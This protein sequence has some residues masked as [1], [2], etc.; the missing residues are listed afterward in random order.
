M[1]FRKIIRTAVLILHFISFN[2]LYDNFYQVVNN[3]SSNFFNFY[4]FMYILTFF[5]F[6]LTF[7]KHILEE[8]LNL[9]LKSNVNNYILNKFRRS[10]E[11]MYIPILFSGY[12]CNIISN[13]FW[14]TVT[15][16]TLLSLIPSYVFSLL[17]KTME[18]ILEK[19]KTYFIK[20]KDDSEYQENITTEEKEELKVSISV[21]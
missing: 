2:Y 16:Q 10:E 20:I 13:N 17:E 6:Y 8:R 11:L 15:I 7:S 21:K 18:T 4:Y 9:I 3:S 19:E 1:I 5:A 14:V 12:V